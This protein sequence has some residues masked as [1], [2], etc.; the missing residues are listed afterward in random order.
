MQMSVTLTMLLHYLVK[1]RNHSLAVD[2]NEFI[3]GSVHVGS[4]WQLLS[5]KKSHVSHHIILITACA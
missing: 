4:D 1:C 3:L 5:P 2:N